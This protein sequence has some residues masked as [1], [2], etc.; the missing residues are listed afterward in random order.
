[1]GKHARRTGNRQTE[2]TGI[3]ALGIMGK[4]G[5]T[6][7]G[8]ETSTKTCETDQ[9]ETMCK[10]CVSVFI[11]STNIVTK[12]FVKHFSVAIDENI[13]D[14]KDPEKNSN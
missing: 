13:T 2:N 8:V 4:M 5:D 12:I 1:M 9:G 11:M 14:S 10:L 3:N 6:W 7:R